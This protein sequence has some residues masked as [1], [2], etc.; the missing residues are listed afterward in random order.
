MEGAV[1]ELV[2]NHKVRRL[3]LLFERAD[4]RDGEDP[5]HAQHLHREDVGAK[6]QFA[7]QDTMTA[8]VARQKSNLAT[9][10]FADKYVGGIAKG[11]RSPHLLR[12]GKSGHGVQAAAADDANFCL[13]QTGSE[14][15]G[16]A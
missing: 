12:I 2:R 14:R 7:G 16:L 1:D 9:F 6:V 5:L 4:G 8:S 3:M 13:L 10:K 15:W 11:R